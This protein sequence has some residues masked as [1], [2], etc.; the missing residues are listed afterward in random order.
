MQG[1]RSDMGLKGRIAFSALTIS[2]SYGVFQWG[3]SQ[4]G[5]TYPFVVSLAVAAIGL[6]G[7][8]YCFSRLPI[9]VD[10]RLW[11]RLVAS[12]VI[13]GLFI[14]PLVGQ[15]RDRL[16]SDVLELS[17]NQLPPPD[18]E[19]LGGIEWHDTYVPLKV[20]INN[21]SNVDITDLELSI[22]PDALIAH[23]VQ[24][25][26]LPDVS[27]S[28]AATFDPQETLNGKLQS[29]ILIAADTGYTV[30]APRLPKYSGIIVLF[31]LIRITEETQKRANTAGDYVRRMRMEGWLPNG[32]PFYGE[33][34]EMWYGKFER[35]NPI[36]FAHGA[37]SQHV[38][39]VGRFRV[40]YSHEVAETI[41]VEHD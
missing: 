37:S 41:D 7:L 26:D 19:N 24:F 2:I 6:L 22:R 5:L 40:G 32:N 15:I 31:A 10:Q 33:N 13:G 21:N 34:F 4:M 29:A 23:A 11:I 35:V 36:V 12:L 3:V 30:T 16:D 1:Q 39:I 25:D 17:A 18:G 20:R 38:K 28:R 9:I 8:L 27:I 14:L